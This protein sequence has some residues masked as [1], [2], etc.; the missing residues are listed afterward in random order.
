MIAAIVAALSFVTILLTTSVM[1]AKGTEMK[2]DY[3][4]KL[5][6]MTDQINNAQSFNSKIDEKN[7][8]NISDVR[9]TYTTKDDIARGVDTKTLT[10]QY[11]K[12][13]VLDAG[14][15]SGEYM[16][17]KTA[18]TDQMRV[19]K[20]VSQ[21]NVT[22]DVNSLNL[23]TS[24][25]NLSGN[26]FGKG[27]IS[28]G[29]SIDGADSGDF[30]MQ[31]GIGP[32]KNDVVMKM[33]NG[34][35]FGVVDKDGKK[36]VSLDPTGQVTI[37]DWK[38]KPGGDYLGVSVD[39]SDFLKIQKNSL[40]LNTNNQDSDKYAFQAW[41]GK[42]EVLGVYNDG[43][44]KSQGGNLTGWNTQFMNANGGAVKMN[45]GDGMGISV[46][47]NN[48][49]QNKYAFQA[50]NGKNELLGVYN[51]GVLKSE[52][53][54]K[55]G[56]NV[57][58]KSP[59]GG[60]VTMNR[61]DGYGLQVNTNSV[62][63]GKYAMQAWN[64]KNELLG[65]YN[66]GTLKS[67]GLNK[68]G[69]NVNFK[70][71][72]GG[73]VTMNR[74][75]GYGMQVNTNS[76]D[77][78]KYAM[79]AWN[80]KNELLGVYND[81]TL[82]SEGLNKTGWNVN[83]K[84]PSG[85]AVSMNRADGYGMQVNT[86]SADGGKYAL[87]AWNGKNELLGVYNDGIIKSEGMNAKDWNFQQK[88]ANGGAVKMNRGDGLGISVNTNNNESSKYAFQAWNGKN[89]LLGVYNDGV[90]RSEGLNKDGWNV[91]FMNPNSGSVVMNKADGS[92]MQ[93]NTNNQDGGKNALEISDGK[94]PLLQVRN[95]GKQI[96]WGKQANDW[97]WRQ[98]NTNGGNVH[99]N[100][101]QGYGAHINTNNNEGNKYG[102]QVFNGAKENLTVFYDGQI[103][104]QNRN[105][106]WTHFNYPDGKNYIR[107]DTDIN[108][109]VKNDKLQVGRD[110]TSV[111][112]A[113]SEIK[114][115][116]DGQRHYS[117][118][119]TN[120]TLKIND[121]SAN[122]TLG[123]PGTNLVSIDPSKVVLKD[124]SSFCIA[125]ACVDKSKLG[126]VS[127]LQ[128]LQATV[129]QLQKQINSLTPQQLTTLQTQYQQQIQQT[130]TQINQIATQQ[131][132]QQ[133]LTIQQQIDAINV[134]LKDIKSRMSMPS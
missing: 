22:S 125:D 6:G 129:A 23:N 121:T 61:A 104:W 83:L 36:A 88:N 66:D 112:M 122:N 57:D 42:A 64:G 37:K 29:S 41:N 92:G 38:I 108:G 46:N 102:L 47:T 98:Y 94:S 32:L 45:R 26:E 16:K 81:G 74:A 128:T 25:V 1:I 39:N 118:F 130:Q 7:F 68:T 55:T 63:G 116:N 24:R 132:A 58:F 54:N 5:R 106:T 91:N 133:T 50:W 117:V 2:K 12:T 119:N 78:G 113:D 79:Q 109:F 127:Q 111:Q 89:E 134:T 110:G 10:T 8:D 90:L 34:S 77:G 96:N 4:D 11:T 59:S 56:W 100:H 67:E 84:S 76:V 126:S 97:N 28:F 73:A 131:A 48:Q 72:S 40:L 27:A 19:D 53:L 49:E 21:M 86:N 35:S 93:I 103:R 123:T 9:K 30:L 18:S 101:G 115:R 13:K 52:G 114:M 51:D 105:G 20:L 14:T 70:S 95:D 33:P 124:G 107:G 120:G 69:W 99:M 71:P 60:A 43:V 75:D 80:G 31:R 65:V 62:D 82:K 3:D 87:Q 85:G 44:L 17:F 15:I